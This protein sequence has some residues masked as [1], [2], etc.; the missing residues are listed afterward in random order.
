LADPDIMA[1]LPR[2]EIVHDPELDRGGAGK[3]H[4]VH[5][6]ATLKDGRALSTYVEQRR[7]SAEHP[8]SPADVEQKF[9]RLAATSLSDA[10]TTKV[11]RIVQHIEQEAHVRSLMSLLANRSR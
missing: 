5:L 6:A 2:I 7:G 3:R 1:L 9:R 4:A 10:D 8:L 11:M